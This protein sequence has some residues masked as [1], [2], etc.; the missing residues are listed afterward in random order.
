MT[1]L[2]PYQKA[3]N[4]IPLCEKAL[5]FLHEDAVIERAQAAI[6]EMKNWSP[7][8]NASGLPLGDL[9]M[10]ESEEGLVS[11]QMEASDD[12]AHTTLAL[13]CYA[14]AYVSWHMSAQSGERPH[15]MVIE[16]TEE[17]CDLALLEADKLKLKA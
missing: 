1:T 4:L 14:A 10:D 17:T 16:V 12:A 5:P 11:D 6:R 7:D 9:L 15:N 13:L 8:R 2:S 3:Q